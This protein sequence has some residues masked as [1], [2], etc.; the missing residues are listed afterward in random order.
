MTDANAPFAGSHA[1]IFGGAKGIGRAV[2]ME[3]AKRGAK[4]YHRRSAAEDAAKATAAEIIAGG[5]AVALAACNVLSDKSI[6][7]TASAAENAFGP[8][9]ILMNNVGGMLNGHPEDIPYA[10]WPRIME[11][12][13]FRGGAGLHAF[14]A[15]VPRARQWPHR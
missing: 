6:A 7:A 9:D 12:Q 2:A 14:P 5:E 11:H 8:V 4:V 15:E 1:L 10:E 3:W 13:L